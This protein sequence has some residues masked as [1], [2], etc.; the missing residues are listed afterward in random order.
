MRDGLNEL[1][2]LAEEDIKW[3]GDAAL[4]FEEMASQLHEPEKSNWGSRAAAYR[5]R[6]EV[7][8]AVVENLRHTKQP[9]K[10]NILNRLIGG[11]GA[12]W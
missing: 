2:L 6:A 9:A 7:H 3:L 12:P 1:L 8:L 4:R 11:L 5:E 10:S